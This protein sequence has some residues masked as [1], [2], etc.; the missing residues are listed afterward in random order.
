MGE[1]QAA[2][3]YL[4]EALTE[5]ITIGATPLTLDALVGVAQQQIEVGQYVSAAELLGLTLSHPALE[6]DSSQLAELVLERL[7]NLL[8]TDQLETA[9]EHGKMLELDTVVAKLE[10]MVAEILRDQVE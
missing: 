6:I 8:P 2:W 5:S 3:K 10:V 1:H 9:L 4:L 7:H